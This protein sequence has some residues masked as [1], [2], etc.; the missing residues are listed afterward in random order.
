MDRI[1][2]GAE[3]TIVA[4][5]GDNPKYG[6]PGV[7]NRRR[8]SQP[9][10]EIGKQKFLSTLMEPQHIIQES[11]WITRGWTYQEAVLSTRRLLFTDSQVYFECAKMNCCEALDPG[12]EGLV[13]FQRTGA[14]SGKR[15]FPPIGHDI[16][17]HI[18]AYSQRDL[19]YDS[20]ALNGISGIFRAYEQLST[21]IYQLSAIPFLPD[22][23]ANSERKQTRH[24][25]LGLCWN[26]N[27]EVQR[28]E[29]F[30]SWSWTGWKGVVT[31][32]DLYEVL[33]PNVNCHFAAIMQDLQF[34]DIDSM[35]LTHETPLKR[36]CPAL[37]VCGDFVT[38]P[39]I[40]YTPPS[41]VRGL[42]AR[43]H[44]NL[45][46]YR[47]WLSSHPRNENSSTAKV[48]TF[49]CFVLYPGILLVL[50]RLGEGF[51]ERIGIALKCAR[52]VYQHILTDEEF[53]QCSEE[54]AQCS[55]VSEIE[56]LPRK[57]KTVILV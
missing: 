51:A 13:A 48:A 42:F 53:T 3:L 55:E 45:Y 46:L 15:L 8:V 57:R 37:R 14:Y 23:F 6:L 34:I 54:F 16:T 44:R 35:D 21:P 49:E 41:G 31:W 47:V 28:R 30:P 22:Q 52:D 39:F 17:R 33:E 20:D 12:Y 10:V 11:K 40:F 1:F 38:A 24:F 2:R 29:G 26:H 5:A 4:A 50:R 27:T 56:K 25:A 43:W 32:G 7:K 19:T 18:E 36:S 9:T